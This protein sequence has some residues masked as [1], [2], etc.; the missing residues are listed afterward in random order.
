M[1]RV[2]NN[3]GMT[4]YRQGTNGRR[5]PVCALALALCAGMLA[6]PD[7]PA[8]GTGVNAR[9][10]AQDLIREASSQAI[11][12]LASRREELRQ[13]NTRIYEFVEEFLLPHFDSDYIARLVLGRYWRQ[14]SPEERERFRDAFQE[15]LIRSY[16]SSM[17]E[18]SDQKIT[19]L[20][21]S[22]PPD[23]DETVVRTEVELAS[24]PVAVDY[25]L[26]RRDGRWLVYDVSIDGISMVVNYRG[27]INS[28][29]RRL[30]GVAPLIDLIEQRNRRAMND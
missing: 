11:D 23:A 25:S 8:A 3:G 24:G 21:Y 13:D 1:A 10:S 5:A 27:N 26:R 4:M 16:A 19:Y 14:A 30:N 7:M 6:A 2:R 29:I 20:P 18:Y 17:L 28:E 22:E 9:A 12:A 15:M